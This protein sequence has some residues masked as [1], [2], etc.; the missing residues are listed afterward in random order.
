MKHALTIACL[1]L[2]ASCASCAC[3]QAWPAKPVRLVVPNAPGGTSDIVARLLGDHLGRTT[4]RQFVV[5]NLAAGSGMVAGQTVARATPDGYTLLFASSATLVTNAL[6]IRSLTYDPVKDFIPVGLVIDSAPFILALHPD[7]PASNVVDLVALAKAQPG[8]LAYATDTPRGYSVIIGQLFNKR[9]GTNVVEITYKAAPPALQDTV[10]GRTQMVITAKGVVDPF[11]KAGKLKLIA[12]TS[13][14]RFPGYPDLP[15][16][17]ETLPGFKVEGWFAVV[18]P[19]GTPAEIVSRANAEVQQFVRE[20]G[21]PEKLAP[22]GAVPRDPMPPAKVGEF[23]DAERE[24]WS[25]I[26][27]EVGLQPE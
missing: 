14:K 1:W 27:R 13:A 18:A 10:A 7:V 11:V 25:R 16:V 23:I 22:F 9:A 17:A 12:I 24:N 20:P 19:V 2:G 3:A 15:A 8:K 4:G 26:A 6:M 21:M 5:E